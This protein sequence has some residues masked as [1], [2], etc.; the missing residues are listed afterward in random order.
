LRSG[1]IAAELTSLTNQEREL[2]NVLRPI[3][4]KIRWHVNVKDLKGKLQP[5]NVDLFIQPNTFVLL[6]RIKTTEKKNIERHATQLALDSL[7]IKKR[8][9]NSKVFCI[10]ET[11][12]LPNKAKVVLDECLDWWCTSIKEFANR[13][14]PPD[15]AG[16]LSG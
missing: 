8:N 14:L 4:K 7:R 2:M 12:K 1:F 15:G 5:L 13:V 9:P 6:R 10:F 11:E 16:V 3:N